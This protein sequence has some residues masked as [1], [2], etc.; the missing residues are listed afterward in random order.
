VIPLNPPAA[1]QEKSEALRELVEVLDEL[2]YRVADNATRKSKSRT[3]EK[4]QLSGPKPVTA[5]KET[6]ARTGNPQ[7]L[8][9]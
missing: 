7:P 1:E 8:P 3:P 6:P 2:C 4:T 5:H 9:K